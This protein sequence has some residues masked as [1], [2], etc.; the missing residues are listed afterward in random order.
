MAKY[1]EAT[2][3]T[4]RLSRGD[5]Q[6]AFE[7]TDDGVGFDPNATGYGTACKGWPTASRRLA[8]SSS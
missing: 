7:I 5:G 4:V 2:G 1:A 3:A 6:L 8:A